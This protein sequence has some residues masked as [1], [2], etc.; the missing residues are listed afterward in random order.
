MYWCFHCYGVNPRP[1]GPCI[2]CGRP[3]EAPSDLSSEQRLIWTLGH[4][5]GDRAVTAAQTLG[6]KR[7]AA[8]LPALRQVV[9]EER[10]PYLA[11][12][13]LRSLIAIAGA[14]HSRARL[15]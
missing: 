6:R 12:E 5:D 2:H 11:A 1:S 3:V 15:E 8:A 4:P 14:E 13:V 10:D 9:T 7:A